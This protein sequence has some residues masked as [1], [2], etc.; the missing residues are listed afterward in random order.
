MLI[1]SKL[2]KVVACIV[3]LFA[4]TLTARAANIIINGDFELGNTGFNSSYNYISSTGLLGAGQYTLVTDPSTSHSHASVVSYG[5]HT[6]GSGLMMMVNGATSPITVWSQDVT[7]TPNTTYKFSGFTST[8]LGGLTVLD[9]RVDGVSIGTGDGA[10]YGGIW[11]EFSYIFNSGALSS[12]T[13][14]IVDLNTV[15]GGNDF[16]LD[17][18]SLSQVPIPAAVWLFASGIL[19]LI[20]LGRVSARFDAYS[21]TDPPPAV[22]AEL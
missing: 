21:S 12:T 9:V 11:E 6:S 3:M 1:K 18:L 7:L 14:E 5:D 17:D 19:C 16:A 8:W 20:G 15:L 13:I 10:P 22:S 2:G 4:S